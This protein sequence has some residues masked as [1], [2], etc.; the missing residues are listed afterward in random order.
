M[1]REG[2]DF[3]SET[4]GK[5]SCKGGKREISNPEIPGAMEQGGGGDGETNAEVEDSQAGAGVKTGAGAE[6]RTRA[7]A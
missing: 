5:I 2:E 1:E 4:E 6:V 3:I 7:E